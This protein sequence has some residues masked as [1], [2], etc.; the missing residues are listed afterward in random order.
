MPEAGTAQGE[1]NRSTAILLAVLLIVFAVTAIRATQRIKRHQEA[2]RLTAEAG[3]IMVHGPG[4]H[5]H[6]KGES[7]HEQKLSPADMQKAY[8][9]AAAMLKRS[10][11]LEPQNAETW[12]VLGEISRRQGND[13][14]AIRHYERSIELAPKEAD[15]HAG[16]AEIYL[17]R[18][19]W[20]MARQEYE[21]GLACA[22][23]DTGCLRF[24]ILTCSK[25]K[26]RKATVDYARRLRGINKDDPLARM[27]LENKL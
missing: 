16:L 25:Q 6:A 24:L 15:Y 11:E 19:D 9:Q 27:A 21:A 20:K 22:P 13:A 14:E 2:M 18:K 23:K 8:K 4:G 12:M 17:H 10:A 3:E 1:P 7:C 5:H 26:D